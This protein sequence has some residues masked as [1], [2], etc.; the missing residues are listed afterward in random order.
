MRTWMALACLCGVAAA[1]PRA[2]RVELTAEQLAAQLAANGRVAVYS[3]RFAGA[4]LSPESEPMLREIARLVAAQPGLT[5]T[6]EG[7]TD[8]R[9]G[10]AANLQLSE[11][12][13]R[14]VVAWLVARGAPAERL[15]AE[16]L[17]EA[18]PICRGQ[19][20]ACRA[21]NRRIELRR[22]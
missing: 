18:R 12:R 9:G 8:D 1:A 3:I 14:A 7:H 10:F 19:V 11:E 2:A 22:E 17:G 21:R 15:R 5:L 4:R 13:A 20:A 16:G 6:V